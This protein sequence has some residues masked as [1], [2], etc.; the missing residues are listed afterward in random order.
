MMFIT[1]IPPTTSEITAM[2]EIKSVIVPVVFST[3]C[4][5]LSLLF[6]KKSS[7]PCRAFKSS[8]R[9]F[10]ATWLLTSSLIFTV[11]ELA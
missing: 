6:M 2:L 1:P 8:V 5:M 4:L 11:I 3:I 10:S 7:V 9:L